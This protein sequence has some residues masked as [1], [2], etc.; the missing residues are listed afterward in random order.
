LPSRA[1]IASLHLF[2]PVAF[3]VLDPTLDRDA[4]AVLE[5]LDLSW[6]PSAAGPGTMAAQLRRFLG[7]R[8]LVGCAPRAGPRRVSASRVGGSLRVWR[9]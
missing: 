1:R 2:D 8:R 7:R 4:R 6:G 5:A 9:A 3:G